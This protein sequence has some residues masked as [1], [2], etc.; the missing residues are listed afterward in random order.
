M[1][2]LRQAVHQGR[3]VLDPIIRNA[4]QADM[5]GRPQQPLLQV[6]PK[7]VVDGQRDDERSHP[8]RHPGDGNPRDDP[9]KRLPAF[10]AQVT[11]RDEEF[12]AHE[13][14]FSLSAISLQPR[15]R[16]IRCMPRWTVQ[17]QEELLANAPARRRGESLIGLS[18]A[19]LRAC[20]FLQNAMRCRMVIVD[21]R[22]LQQLSSGRD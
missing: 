1:R 13:E 11:S 17:R 12:E 16:I 21:I 15:L 10:G 4:L 20:Q 14:A 18:D 9:N 5:R 7:P 19:G 3:P 6:L 8:R 22:S 2:L